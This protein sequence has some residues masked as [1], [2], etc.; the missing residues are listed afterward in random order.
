M[1][2]GRAAPRSLRYNL[3]R[4]SNVSAAQRTPRALC[5]LVPRARAIAQKPKLPLSSSIMGVPKF[6]RWLS[7][8]YPLLNQPVKLR[9]APGIDNLVRSCAVR[10]FVVWTLT[11]TSRARTPQFL[12]LNGVIHNCSHGA[13]TDHSTRMSE[14]RP[15][16]CRTRETRSIATRGLRNSH[17][18]AAR[19]AQIRPV[20]SCS[21]F[22]PRRGPPSWLRS[23]QPY[24]PAARRLRATP[25]PRPSSDARCRRTR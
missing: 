13:G 2:S 8:R 23:A 9:G 4:V 11:L 1:Q 15:P 5:R 25:T 17:P 18:R 7:E 16:C 20:A 14:E 12:D 22:A 19:T 6:Y 3:Q 24:P 21:S 10:L